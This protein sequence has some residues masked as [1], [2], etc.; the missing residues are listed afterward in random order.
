MKTS[1]ERL[2]R[3][4][5]IVRGHYSTGLDILNLNK[6]LLIIP[7]DYEMFFEELSAE[8]IDELEILGWGSAEY[9]GVKG[10]GFDM[11]FSWT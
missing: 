4:L 6:D 1:L 2:I 11:T 3:G 7:M 9:K 5:E 10:I 8:E